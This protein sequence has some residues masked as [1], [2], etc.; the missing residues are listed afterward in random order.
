[1]DEI[2][3]PYWVEKESRYSDATNRRYLRRWE[4]KDDSLY[5]C[6]R[7]VCSVS[8]DWYSVYLSTDD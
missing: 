5:D 4:L 3:H 2:D 1:L 7:M 8:G 6:R